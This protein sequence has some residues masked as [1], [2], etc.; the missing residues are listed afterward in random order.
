MFQLIDWY[1]KF[2]P[3]SMADS[4]KKL[5]MD[6]LDRVYDAIKTDAIDDTAK[7]T[8]LFKLLGIKWYD[9]AADIMESGIAHMAKA[10]TNGK[11]NEDFI[12]VDIPGTPQAD[13]SWVRCCH[14]LIKLCR[15][16]REVTDQIKR[17][18][19]PREIVTY[20]TSQA[21]FDET[22]GDQ[23]ALAI[24]STVLDLIDY[25]TW[26][27]NLHCQSLNSLKQTIF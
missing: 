14:Y 26:L 5:D 20:V 7:F 9:N 24:F 23:Q 4:E 2:S 11:L 13:I 16:R 8:L 6:M 18:Q 10:Y 17:S 15:K 12:D 21:T 25:W 1:K 3:F 22:S 19:W 27:F